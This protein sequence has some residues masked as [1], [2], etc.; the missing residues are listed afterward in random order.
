LYSWLNDPI[1]RH[2]QR[3]FARLRSLPRYHITTTDI[4]G[5]SIEIVDSLSFLYTYEAIFEQQV[6]QF[7]ASSNCPYI[8]DGGANIGL[9]TLYF[10]RLYPSSRVVAF[11]P[12]KQIFDVLQRNLHTFGINDVEAHC[13]ALWSSSEVLNFIDEGADAGRIT[14]E[15]DAN[16]MHVQAVRLREYLHASVDFLKLDIEGAEIE[17][18]LDCADLLFKVRNLFVEYHSFIDRP[19]RLHILVNLLISAGFRIHIHS[20]NE[21][22]RPFIK[23][24]NNLGMDMVLNIFA[25]RV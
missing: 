23:R 2:K 1:Y 3:E 18:L 9:S 13:L 25:F 6:Y 19:Q 15:H 17:V 5:K 7:E 10:K 20:S 11:E 12:D 4:L 22:K 16:T 8:I 21:A 14:Q 24:N